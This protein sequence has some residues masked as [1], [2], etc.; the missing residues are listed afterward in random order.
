MSGFVDEVVM[1]PEVARRFRQRTGRTTLVSPAEKSVLNGWAS[2][3]LDFIRNRWPVRTGLSRASWEVEPI[4]RGIGLRFYNGALTPQARAYA[5][6]VHYAGEA[7][8]P[9]LAEQHISFLRVSMREPLWTS[10]RAVSTP[11]RTR[12]PRAPLRRRPR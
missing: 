11:P 7:P 9:P 5:G 6:F 1:W 4:Y 3:A 8:E 2:E 10:L 12:R